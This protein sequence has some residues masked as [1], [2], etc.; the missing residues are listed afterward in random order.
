M[1]GKY[2]SVDLD[3]RKYACHFQYIAHD[4]WDLDAVSPPILIDVKN[5]KGETV[6]GLL[7]AG[8]TGHVYVHDRRDCSMIRFTEAMVP[9]QAAGVPVFTVVTAWSLLGERLDG[10][11]LAGI[12]VVIGGVMLEFLPD[13]KPARVIGPRQ[14]WPRSKRQTVKR[15]L[16]SR[17]TG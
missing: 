4:V 12:S 13:R 10:L 5:K 15:C 8:K 7:H 6:P 3:T 2:R 14:S 17:Q 16:H 1:P 9:L 11:A